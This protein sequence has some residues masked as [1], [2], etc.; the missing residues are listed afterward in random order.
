MAIFKYVAKSTKPALRV[1]IVDAE[2]DDT[3]IDL[4][5]TGVLSVS[6]KFR[7]MSDRDT[8]LWEKDATYVDSG[9]NGVTDLEFS[10]TDLDQDTGMYELEYTLNYA[11][12]DLSIIWKVLKMRIKEGFADVA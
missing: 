12:P 10:A 8:T 4:Q 1:T 7:S 9:V 6:V 3:P 2:N 5:A 11:D